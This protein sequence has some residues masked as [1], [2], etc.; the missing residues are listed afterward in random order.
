MT[1]SEKLCPQ[2]ERTFPGTETFCPTDGARLI[3]EE[4]DELLGR[5]IE[6]RY[7]ID[8]LLGQ[9][10]MGAVYSA[11]QHSMDREIALKV[12]KPEFSK[13]LDVVKRF[14]RE[15]KAASRLSNPHTISVYDFGRTEDGVL[16]LAMEKLLGETL[17]SLLKR[18]GALGENRA[19][20][21]ASQMCESL[22][23]A[24]EQGLVHRD[25]KPENVFV[26]NPGTAREFVKVL[27]FGI[28]KSF[29]D[30]NETALT[31]TGMVCGTPEYMSPEHASG[32]GATAASDVYSVGI[33]LYQMLCGV[34]PFDYDSPMDVLIKHIQVAPPPIHTRVENN[35]LS[36]VLADLV[37]SCLAKKPEERPRDAGVLLHALLDEAAADS[38]QA[39]AT[40]AVTAPAPPVRSKKKP[41]PP[42]PEKFFPDTDAVAASA[43]N[44]TLM[45][46]ARKY[47]PALWPWLVGGLA[48]LLALGGVFLR[49]TLRPKA[50]AVASQPQAQIVPKLALAPDA[51]ETLAAP[52]SDVREEA[53][54][55]LAAAADAVTAPPEPVPETVAAPVVPPT[56]ARKPVKREPRPAQRKVAKPKAV[57][58]FHVRVESVPSGAEVS[59]NGE[60]LG[61]APLD[62]PLRAGESLRLRKAG[63][64]DARATASKAWP[65]TKRFHMKRTDEAAIKRALEDGLK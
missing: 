18:E 23:E 58:R 21:I 42:A 8:F 46:H 56:P 35:S 9:G 33:V 61:Y 30:P 37:D 22:A 2:C 24:H 20:K 51:G 19:R 4:P 32:R 63:Y 59:R 3:G 7:R 12:L 5:D 40:R 11:T 1:S 39:N 62:I 34:T 38:L 15:A 14:L 48:L 17:G 25:V 60:R 54:A 50:G 53:T 16:Y 41:K 6:G 43:P 31:S 29:S 47:R 45:A 28:A 65:K 27:D 10:G 64:Q 55:K 36:P 49:D 44:S 52:R 13:K 57:P 26:L